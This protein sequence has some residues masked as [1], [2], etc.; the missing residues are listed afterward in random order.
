MLTL[1]LAEDSLLGA[2]VRH[3]IRTVI[4]EICET[5]AEEI[6]WVIRDFIAK[7]FELEERDCSFSWEYYNDHVAE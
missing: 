5:I 1:C 6:C 3:V 2:M 4:T 7:R